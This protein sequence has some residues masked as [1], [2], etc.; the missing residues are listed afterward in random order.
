[1]ATDSNGNFTNILFGPGSGNSPALEQL[2]PSFQQDLNGDGTIGVPMTV[3]EAF[4]STE[5]AQAGGNYFLNPV[6]GGMGPELKLNGTPVTV[7]QFGN[8]PPIG[9][10]AITGGY[11]VAWKDMSSGQ[12]TVW[13]TDTNGNFT[14]ILYAVGSGSSIAFEQLEASF[15]QDLNG[16]GVIGVPMTVIEAFGSTALVQAGNNY[17]LNPV[18][19]GT[20]PSL[21]LSGT[22][23][24]VGQFGNEP[25]I[26]V[27]AI[28]GGYE[29]A[30]KDMSN[31]QYT[32]WATDSNGNFTSILY[33]PGAGN[34]TTFGQL[35]TSFQQDLN[36]NGVTG[37][38]G[39]TGHAQF[40]GLPETSP[41]TGL[42]DSESRGLPT[43]DTND[44]F[45]F[46]P[47]FFSGS[48][49]R[50]A[51]LSNM[52]ELSS[53]LFDHLHGF[54]VVQLHAASESADHVN[55]MHVLQDHHDSSVQMPH[56][57]EWHDNGF[58]FR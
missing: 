42:V 49:S 44:S 58:I 25:P 32:V 3:I 48:G 43:A 45:V 51:S 41:A 54:N 28:T 2:E 7:G 50:P 34:T 9:V 11:E 53:G 39:L 35:E 14:S 20:G 17:F 46:R 21:K 15:H 22:P 10:E 8:E 1:W 30:W 13:A 19:G 37:A 23:V 26:G 38:T 5:L 18:A 47:E 56:L 40:G 57:S 4:G 12:Y 16:D 55:E 29:V 33:G 36:G 24:T 52:E 31:G 6:A 27:E